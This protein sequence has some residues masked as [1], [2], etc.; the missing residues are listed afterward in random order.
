M[1][2]AS[3]SKPSDKDVLLNIVES[4]AIVSFVDKGS[5]LQNIKETL[6]VR[7]VKIKRD[8]GEA[9]KKIIYTKKGITWLFKTVENIATFNNLAIKKEKLVG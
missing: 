6:Y 7:T 9:V 5:I 8:N 3:F 1:S 2:L 4:D